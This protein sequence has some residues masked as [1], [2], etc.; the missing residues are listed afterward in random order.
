[1]PIAAAATATIVR[2]GSITRV[3]WIV[4]SSLPGTLA[5]SPAYDVDER[6]REDDAERRRARRSTSS[7]AFSTLLARRHASALPCSVRWRVKV[8]HERG[9]H[10]AFGE[11][12]AHEV[13][14]AERDDERVHLVAGAEE[15]GEHLIAREAE[16]AAGE[17]GGA[18]DA[19][20]AREPPPV[21]ASCPGRTRVRFIGGERSTQKKALPRCGRA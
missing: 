4:S 1:M 16:E 18:G 10:R 11:E 8:G 9:A 21:A 13:G 5:K 2:N 7:S 6:P 3:S 20:G 15:R 12:I 19:G 14:N 17:R